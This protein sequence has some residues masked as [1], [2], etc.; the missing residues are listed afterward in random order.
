MKK[1]ILILHFLLASANFCIAEGPAGWQKSGANRY[2][3]SLDG[4]WQIESGDKTGAG[5][6][7]PGIIKGT[8][9]VFLSRSFH[10]SDSL[11]NY[12]LVLHAS[13]VQP[14][15]AVK[16][17]GKFIGNAVPAINLVELAL[18]PENLK[19][20]A[21]N[22]LTFEINPELNN[23]STLPFKHRPLGL[24]LDSG[25]LS[26]V[27]IE[28]MPQWNLQLKNLNYSFTKAW[29]SIAV[30]I[31]L[32]L[33]NPPVTAKSNASAE[34]GEIRI[35]LRKDGRE[36]IRSKRIEFNLKSATRSLQGIKFNAANISPWSPQTAEIYQL[37][38]DFLIA[39][40]LVDSIARPTGFRELK[41]TGK[42]FLL[43]GKEFLIK[44]VDW[45][46]DLAGLSVEKRHVE[47]QRLI[48]NI[49]KLGANTLRSVGSPAPL[50]MVQKCAENGILLLQ[51]IPVYFANATQLRN[52]KIRS[53]AE[54]GLQKLIERDKLSP[55]ILGW[56][57]GVNFHDSAPAARLFTESLIQLARQND[58]RPV[59][60]M[61]RSTM[62]N[63][64]LEAVDFL[65]FDN[66]EKE[67]LG[68]DP[69]LMPEKPLLPVLGYFVK[70][71]LVSKDY[72][73]PER[74]WQEAEEIQAE[75]LERIV[76]F[77]HE[78]WPDYSG[79]FVH[80]LQDWRGEFATLIIGERKN[81]KLNYPAG[82]LRS[83]GEARVAFQMM[84]AL[85]K[86][87][88]RPNISANSVELENP[89]VFALVGVLVVLMFLFYLKRDRRLNTTIRRIFVHP[90]G[91][92]IDLYEN[93]KVPVFITTIVA[94]A[95]SLVLA[96]LLASSF[97][98]CR[99]FLLFDEIL[100]LLLPSPEL[101]NW[102]IMLIWNP[103]WLIFLLAAAYIFLT[104]ILALLL[105]IL[106][107]MLSKPVSV[108][109][110]TTFLFWAATS[111]LP[112]ALVTPVFYRILLG[113]EGISVPLGIIAFF[114]IWHLLRVYRGMRVLMFLPPGRA[115]VLF[116]S[117]LFIL[118]GS[119]AFYYNHSQS[120]F[121]YIDYYWSLL[122]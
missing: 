100:N 55:A 7:V 33:E 88:R 104:I 19:Y 74:R 69:A 105:R 1:L 17:N 32:E 18:N 50:D 4:K 114:V 80:A 93:R 44:G 79:S 101:K 49:K 122:N 56:G 106:G 72:T 110:Y 91:F 64:S 22:V 66:F 42:K 63:A 11:K 28:A 98:A 103:G 5:L 29:T 38:I 35:H 75:Q 117:I 120:I 6:T 23:R 81:D 51:E 15:C 84:A 115:F 57:I 24:R 76:R 48:D 83:G 62:K 21:E 58:S 78:S 41:I 68:F 116:I 99:E 8:E 97:F 39:G 77:L 14:N 16:L 13:S 25:I 52:K 87:E 37:N 30:K 109:Q 108:G 92:Y 70:P 107:F 59:Y 102:L 73:Q 27:Y 61:T 60:L 65:L 112:L 40:K 36:V 82:L 67:N 113:D 86:S 94:C 90:H 12:Q 71:F 121:A 54:A 85:N 34:R 89:A 9:I 118:F 119:I 53:D 20:G 3:L 31:D 2:L 47:I 45:F 111:Y 10:L 46:D 95:Q 26:P 96:L 43:N